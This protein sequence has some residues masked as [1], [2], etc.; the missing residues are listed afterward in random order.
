MGNAQSTG[1]AG[2]GPAAPD[3]GDTKY[4]YHVLLV[5]YSDIGTVPQL[6][7]PLTLQVAAPVRAVR[8]RQVQHAS[9]AEEAGLEAYFDF[10]V[11]INGHRLVR[12]PP[13]LA[14]LASCGTAHA[15]NPVDLGFYLSQDKDDNT[16]LE[17]LKAHVNRP[18][19]ATVYSSKT[20]RLRRTSPQRP[21]EPF[22]CPSSNMIAPRPAAGP[23]G[24]D[25]PGAQQQLGRRRPDRYAAAAA[26]ERRGVADQRGR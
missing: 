17:E 19:A 8:A 26:R 2:G 9:P 5:R 1:A 7:P 6:G 16:L 10:L 12:A 11:E 4:G 25:H 20:E 23:A 21:L 22:C 14:V 18:V 15:S 24:R 3:L 13:R